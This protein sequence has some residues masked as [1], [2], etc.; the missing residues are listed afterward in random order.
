MYPL[1][2]FTDS[3]PC[4][5]TNPDSQ[6]HKLAI[7]L[8]SSSSGR[9]NL[10]ARHQPGTVNSQTWSTIYGSAVWWS[11]GWF[12]STHS[13]RRP[14]G[15]GGR[16]PVTKPHNNLVT[17]LRV[18]PPPVPQH[19]WT[20]NNHHHRRCPRRRRPDRVCRETKAQQPRS[21][22]W[23]SGWSVRQTIHIRMHMNDPDKSPNVNSRGGWLLGPSV[24]AARRY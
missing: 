15:V 6:F 21:D 1:H 23:V 22:E 24:R 8:R 11:T 4:C 2:S 5:L 9:I 19:H 17:A 14:R 16:H 20:H 13:L 7:I 18:V 3:L 10:S 12:R